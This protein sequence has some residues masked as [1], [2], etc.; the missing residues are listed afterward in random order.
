MFMK[1][2]QSK[3]REWHV[4]AIQ[5]ESVVRGVPLPTVSVSSDDRDDLVDIDLMTWSI[6]LVFGSHKPTAD[7]NYLTM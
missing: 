6:P 7:R 4:K 5:R 2:G 1:D 3:Q